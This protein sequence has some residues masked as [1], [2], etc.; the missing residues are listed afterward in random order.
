MPIPNYGVLKCH[1]LESV[2]ERGDASPHYQLHAFDGKLDFRVPINVKSQ[3][4]PSEVKYLID[5]N[6]QHEITTGL[7]ALPFGF[8][9]LTK[10]TYGK[11]HPLALDYIRSNLFDINAMV[12]LSCNIPGPANDLNEKI[13]FHIRRSIAVKEAEVYAFGSAWVPNQREA[14]PFHFTP[15]RGVHDIHMNQGND[16]KF[17]KDDG[18][19]QD[20]GILIYYP[21]EDRWTGIFLAFQSQA[22]HTDD[23]TGHAIASDPV[24]T[25]EAERALRII[26]ACVNPEGTDAGQET[27]LLLNTTNRAIDLNGWILANKDKQKFYLKGQINPGDTLKV[28]L[29][30]HSEFLSNQ[31][32]IITL[33]DNHGLK[34][35]GVKYTKKQAQKSGRT[36]HFQ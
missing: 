12:P 21:A 30:G 29:T 1:A 26:G 17:A 36:I 18:V 27:V 9:Q 6:F 32:G 33:L 14:L 22:I 2:M 19:Y 16:P 15:D 34:I 31:G 7:R 23:Q 3:S 11:R 10:D 25:P 35:H 8:T 24:E 5:E 4:A 20:G 13:D 28:F